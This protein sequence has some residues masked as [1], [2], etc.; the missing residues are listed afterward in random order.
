MGQNHEGRDLLTV[1]YDNQSLGTYSVR[2]AKQYIHIKSA[3]VWDMTKGYLFPA[4]TDGPGGSGPRRGTSPLS[5]PQ[6][7]KA[8]KSFIPTL[9]EKRLYEWSVKGG[10]SMPVHIRESYRETRK[11][12]FAA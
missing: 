7:T 2:A 9:W 5:A 4:I 8:F 11:K 10:P 3:A 6:V 1:T 12:Q